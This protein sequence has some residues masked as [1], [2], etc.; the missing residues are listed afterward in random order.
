MACSVFVEILNLRL[1]KKSEPV[2][3]NQQLYNEDIVPV[4]SREG[5]R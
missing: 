5:R 2:H 3:L 4:S 1:R